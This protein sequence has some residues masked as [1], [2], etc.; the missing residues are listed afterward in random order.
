[1]MRALVN[2]LRGE[3]FA[4]AARR[5]NERIDEA[6]RAAVLRARGRFVSVPRVDILNLSATSVAP[7][8]GGVAVQLRARLDTERAL[9]PVALLHP[10]GLE[11]SAPVP[12]ARAGGWR[13]AADFDVAV[14]EALTRSGANAVHIEGTSELPL[15]DV[16]R[17]IDAGVAVVV[18]VHD[19]TLLDAQPRALALQLLRDAR[20]LIF[21]S[22]FLLDAYR[23]EFGLPLAHARI[24]APATPVPRAFTRANAPRGVAFAGSVQ[25]HK[26]GA[27][28]ADIAR[29]LPAQLHLFGGGDVELLR[30]LR[31]LRNVRVHGYYRAGTLPSLLA[32][33][34]IGLVLLPSIVPESYSLVLSE[35]WLAGA[36]VL[37]F[38][39]GATAD[40]IRDEGG[41]LLA[42]LASG[43]DGITTL[44]RRWLDGERPPHRAHA[45]ASPLDAARAHV[46]LYREWGLLPG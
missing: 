14:R 23:V 4:S 3:G 40:R 6:A 9:R 20:G 37:A 8:T 5:A 28:L 7:R 38:D 10:G 21:P 39:L 30:G 29:A 22:R 24:V 26:G 35:S 36:D 44:A 42:P 25:R 2:V 32:R 16:L 41:G 45:I 13:R 17:W 33:H 12:H 18:S 11:C 27:L 31:A 15:A 34:G 1:M 43:A 19:R 46:A